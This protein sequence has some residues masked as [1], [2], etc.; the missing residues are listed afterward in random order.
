MASALFRRQ[1]ALAPQFFVFDDQWRL[2]LE[3]PPRG[4]APLQIVDLALADVDDADGIPEVVV[5]GAGDVG[6]VAVSLTGEVRWRNRAAA[7][8]AVGGGVAA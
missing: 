5:A 4:N 2:L 8:A 6:L 7:N 1:R 3:Y